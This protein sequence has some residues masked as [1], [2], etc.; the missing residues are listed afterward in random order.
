MM[1]RVL[2]L[3]LAL[4]MFA[5][6]A[7]ARSDLPAGNY[8]LQYSPNSSSAQGL[9]LI[10]VEH[11][12]GKDVAEMIE[13]REAEVE[14]FS[15]DDRKVVIVFKGFGRT[16]SFDGAIDPKD[17]KIIVGSFGDDGLITRSMLLPTMAEKLEGTDKIRQIEMP[18]PMA[19]AQKLTSK[20]AGLRLKLRQEKDAEARTALMKD[21]EAA[22]KEADEQVPTLYKELMTKH[23]DSPSIVDAMQGLLASKTDS[24]LK[25][26]E[27]S[28]WLKAVN[29]FATPYG[30]RYRLEVLQK[31]SGQL[32]NQK[33]LEPV[34][35]EA[36]DLAVGALS[37]KTT[38]GQQVKVLKAL[39]TAQERTG[40]ADLAK[41]TD[42]KL[43]KLE[44]VLD[45]EYLAKV[46]PF[47]PTKFQGRKEA[48]ERAVV[49]E[50]FTGAQCPPCVAADAAFDGLLKAYK[51]SELVLIQYHMHIPGPDPL[52]NPDTIARWDYYR[53]LHNRQV[54]GV[55]TSL[56]NG[57][58]AAGGGGGMAN[59]EAKF[60]DFRKVIDP[61][62]EE[63]TTIKLTGKVDVSGEKLAIRVDVDGIKEP[64]DNFRV[65]LLLVEESI[66]YVGGNGIRFHHHVV[67]DMPG[68]VEGTAMKEA[69]GTV[70]ASVDLTALRG[71]LSKYLE[72]FVAD[73]GQ[74]SNPDRPL[75]LKNL[76]VIAIVQDDSTGAILQGLQLDVK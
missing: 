2:V 26:D 25:P 49:M 28:Q 9:F 12:G 20:L 45:Q 61:L 62:L 38:T 70:S 30:P 76:R 55:P 40:K 7:A 42:A 17:D 22:Q 27:A 60:N 37:D 21:I 46:P 64:G 41:Q 35:L 67:R 44:E 59:A 69:K 8:V 31:L 18:E 48:S 50:L 10:K 43:G 56:F 58:P 33:G 51:P 19:K 29:T 14:S 65:R 1:R 23:A 66:R 68:G 39:R 74:F 15:V 47:K 75:A 53:K 63:T 11:K 16:L 34:A 5:S 54:G 24:K 32:A 72:N 13:P 4:G 3:G 71:E 73:G 6:S 52:T 57:K 36:A